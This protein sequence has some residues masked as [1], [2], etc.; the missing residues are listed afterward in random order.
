VIDTEAWVLREKSGS[1]TSVRNHCVS[2]NGVDLRLE[3]FSF[4]VLTAKEVLVEPL[5][6]C[7]EGN[8]CHA[9]RRSPVDI[10]KL[11]QEKRVV[12]GNAGVVRVLQPGSDV[13]SLKEGDLCI[14]FCN[15][16]WDRLGYPQTI[17]GYDAVGTV[18][19][20]A[21]KTKLHERQLIKIPEASRHSLGQWAAF[22]LRYITAWANWNVAYQVWKLKVGDADEAPS[23]WGW[24]GGATLAELAL[25]RIAGCSTFMMASS[26][27]RLSLIEKCGIEAVDR[28]AFGDLDFS[29]EK[30]NSDEQYKQR[31]RKSENAFLEFV[32]QKTD[33]RGVSIFI[34]YIG[35]PVF[36]ASVKSL[37]RPGVIT[38]AGWKKGMDLAIVR[39]IECMNWHSHIHTHY[40]RYP[41][42]LEA[43]KFAEEKGWAP[44]VEGIED[45]V[46]S[47]EEIPSLAGNYAS[48]SLH[49]F[50]PLYQVNPA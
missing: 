24:G 17:Y 21:K 50:F 9:V 25:A 3:T 49:S 26:D 37:S 7:W 36:R 13:S 27:N 12:I 19:I 22:S 10:C 1:G 41:E 38:T 44:P 32:A 16:S 6:G 33:G 35:Q 46:W 34:D 47:W 48:G 23:V 18:G 30:Y 4:P 29:P 15:G 39:A 40:A 14:V 45:K 28:R 42:G 2:Q 31:Y 11:R 5:V 8:M 43:V 20:L